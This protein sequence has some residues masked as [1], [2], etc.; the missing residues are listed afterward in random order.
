MLLKLSIKTKLYLTI[1]VII[2]PMLLVQGYSIITRYNSVIDFETEANEDFAVAI[3]E[4]F[5]N[6][7]NNTGDDLVWR[8][9]KQGR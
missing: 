4:I 2:I 7:I 3:G 6:H 1:F 5:K 8:K 9:N